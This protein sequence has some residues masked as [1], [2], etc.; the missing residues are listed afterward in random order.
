MKRQSSKSVPGGG[1][2]RLSHVHYCT[3]CKIL[4]YFIFFVVYSRTLR[5]E[6]VL[7]EGRGGRWVGGGVRDGNTV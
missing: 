3:L 5:D 2:V 6:T 7:G 1:G 4:F